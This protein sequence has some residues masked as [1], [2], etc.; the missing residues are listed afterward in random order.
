MGK[1]IR[2][3]AVR[4]FKGQPAVVQTEREKA[5]DLQPEESDICGAS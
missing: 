2:G 1:Y 3:Y 5:L 4:L